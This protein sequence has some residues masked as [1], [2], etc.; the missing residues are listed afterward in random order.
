MACAYALVCA[1]WLGAGPGCG[2]ATHSAGNPGSAGASGSSGGAAGQSTAGVGAVGVGGNAGAASGAAG[3]TAGAD[4]GPVVDTAPAT[5]TGPTTDAPA[6]GGDAPIVDCPGG[7]TG[8]QLLGSASLLDLKTCLVWQ[9]APSTTNMTNKRAGKFCATLVQDGWTDWRVPAPEELATWPNIAANAN[10]NAY[11][12]NP[13]YIPATDTVM[14]GCTGDSHSC[15]IAEYN[16]GSLA[17]AWQG[18]DFAG[19]FVCVR[20]TAKPSTTAT[21]YSA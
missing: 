20:G 16:A 9:R 14:A 10:A 4:A 5:D 7:G 2:G 21:A 15:N 6:S 13:I 11:V 3:A 12:T 17:C 19:P 8:T 1:A 18:V